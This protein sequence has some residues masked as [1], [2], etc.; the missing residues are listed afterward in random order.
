MEVTLEYLE[1]SLRWQLKSPLASVYS[2]YSAGTQAHDSMVTVLGQGTFA[3]NTGPNAAGGACIQLTTLQW[4]GIAE[5][6]NNSGNQAGGIF[7]QDSVFNFTGV[8]K[9]IQNSGPSGA[10]IYS[11]TSTINIHVDGNALFQSNSVL[12]DGGT[13]SATSS[14]LMWTGTVNN[15]AGRWGGVIFLARSS[16]T[17]TGVYTY[18][19]NVALS[20]GGAIITV[21][22]NGINC[23]GVGRNSAQRGGAIRT[24][25]SSYLSWNGTI[26][27]RDNSACYNGGG[28]SG[29]VYLD[30]VNIL[31]IIR[32]S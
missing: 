1:N 20:E 28:I 32:Q 7:A 24:R 14:T 8:C 10:A 23:S 19:D 29:Q 25:D 26:H 3:N 9:F 13:I 31:L 2:C 30:G 15:S 27:F 11:L 17:C 21:G 4:S 22:D 12:G 5:V 18:T 6:V 16:L